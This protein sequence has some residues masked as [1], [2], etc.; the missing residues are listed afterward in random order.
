MTVMNWWFYKLYFG[1]VSLRAKLKNKQQSTFDHGSDFIEIF[2]T[3]FTFF[4]HGK[5]VPLTSDIISDNDMRTQKS[6]QGHALLLA[7]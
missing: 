5:Y 7:I 2:H 4:C 3:K 6:A 1:P